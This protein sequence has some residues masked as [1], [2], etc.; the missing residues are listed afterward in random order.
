MERKESK[1]DLENQL[2][3]AGAYTTSGLR[4][5]ADYLVYL[6]DP[7]KVHSSFT[8]SIESN[9]TYKLL[10]ALVRVSSSTKKDTVLATE[11]SKG[12]TFIRY[13]R[14]LENHPEQWLE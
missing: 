9:P 6:D 13:S 14:I 1:I 2:K 4:Y 11:A 7:S 10:A 8:L 5:G 3:E 12:H